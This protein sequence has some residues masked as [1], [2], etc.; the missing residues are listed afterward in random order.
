MA[1]RGVEVGGVSSAAGR[2]RSLLADLEHAV[3]RVGVVDD[4]VVRN[5]RPV[6]ST[7][8]TSGPASGPAVVAPCRLT[9]RAL[10]ASWSAR[11]HVVLGAG[12]W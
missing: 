7:R 2:C 1:E 9:T 5:H 11:C 6:G 10:V 12:R 8:C 3:Q 4:D